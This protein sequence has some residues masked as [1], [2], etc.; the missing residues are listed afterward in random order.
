MRVRGSKSLEFHLTNSQ[1]NFMW[2]LLSTEMKYLALMKTTTLPGVECM[3]F[4]ASFPS[5][6]TTFATL[7]STSRYGS[8]QSWRRR[9]YPHSRLQRMATPWRSCRCISQWRSTFQAPLACTGP[10][11][12]RR[13]R[14][15]K[16]RPS[17]GRRPWL[18]ACPLR[19]RKCR[20]QRSKARRWRH[21]RCPDRRRRRS[22][23]RRWR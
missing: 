8:T 19:R 11:S 9:G 7:P 1:F 3:T 2:C 6:S 13:L 21:V 15:M 23:G 16:G 18:K 4:S 10:R 22:R 5:S 14:C 12:L 20:W 17:K